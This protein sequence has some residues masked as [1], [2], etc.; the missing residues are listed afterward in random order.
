MKTLTS[1]TSP[2][3]LCEVV[4]ANA[5]GGWLAITLAPGKRTVGTEVRWERD[6]AADLDRLEKLGATA[7]VPLLEDHELTQLGIPDLVARAEQRGLAVVRFP[8]RDGAVPASLAAT[9]RLVGDL[10]ARCGRGERVVVHCN[11][12]L[13]RA[14]TIAACARVASG[15]DG[16]A[17]AAIA[18]VRRLRDRRAVE[19]AEQERF[20]ERFAAVWQAERR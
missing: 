3:R 17:S 14:G 18:A 20:V 2:L 13:G 19:N 8:I 5:A 11:G 12:G 10:V 1:A 9:V 16:A 4:P 15:L 6:L 7:L